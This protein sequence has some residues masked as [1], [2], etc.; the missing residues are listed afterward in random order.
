VPNASDLRFNDPLIAMPNVRP[1]RGESD[2]YLNAITGEAG[3]A[4][5]G[6]LRGEP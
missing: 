3:L 1:R 6:D 5:F 4:S 2:S